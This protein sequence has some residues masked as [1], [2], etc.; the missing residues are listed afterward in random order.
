[1]KRV[2]N[3]RPNKKISTKNK[4]SPIYDRHKQGAVYKGWFT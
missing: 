2:E 4:P 3:I 1:M